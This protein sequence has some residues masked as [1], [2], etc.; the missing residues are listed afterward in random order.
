MPNGN[1]VISATKT[2]QKFHIANTSTTTTMT[3]EEF[4][5]AVNLGT[6]YSGQTVYLDE[7]VSGQTAIVGLLNSSHAPLAGQ[8]FSGTFEGQGHTLNVNISDNTDMGAAPFRGINGATIQNLVVSGSVTQHYPYPHASGL[9]GMLSGTNTIKNCL[10]HTNVTNTSYDSGNR[11]IGGITGH[12]LASTLTMEGCVYDGTL[13]SEHP[14][15]GLIG[16]SSASNLTLTN[17]F[18]NGRVTG[19]NVS[20]D[21]HYFHPIGCKDSQTPTVTVDNCYYTLSPT[22]ADNSGTCIVSVSTNK[23][24]F[25]YTITGASGVIVARRDNTTAT[26]NVSQL[27][28][29]N[30]AIVYDGTLYAASGESIPLNLSYPGYSVGAYSANHGTLSGSA[31]T[32]NNDPYTLAMAAYNTVIS[33]TNLVQKFHIANASNTTQMTWA[34]FAAAVN[35]GTNYSGQTVY[36]DEDIISTPAT[37]MVGTV[38]EKFK[39]TFNGQCYTLTVN[40]P[41]ANSANPYAPFCKTENAT[42]KNLKVTGSVNTSYPHASGLIGIVDGTCTI[43]NCVVNVTINSTVSGDCTS[44]GFVAETDSW[45][46]LTMVGCVFTGAFNG[47][48][49][50]CWGGLVGWNYG[51]ANWMMDSSQG[52]KATFTNCLFTPSSINV[53]NSDNAT[54]SRGWNDHTSDLTFNNCYYTQQLGLAQGKRGYT[55]DYAASP[56]AGGTVSHNLTSMTPYDCSCSG[57][58][59]YTLGLGY[60]I[61]NDNEDE[62]ILGNGESVTLTATANAS[63]TFMNWTDNTNTSTVNPYA[64]TMGT[65]NRNVTAR[66][67]NQKTGDDWTYFIDQ[68]SDVPTGGITISSGNVTIGNRE[69]LAW[70]ISMVNALNGVTAE[71]AETFAGLTYILTADVDMSAHTWVPIGTAE[72]PFQGTFEGNG[73]VIT[74]IRRTAEFPHQGLFGYVN[75]A[76]NIQNVVVNA[77][78]TGNSVTT[79]AI[80]G[81]FASTGTISNVEGAGTLTGGALTQSMGGLVGTNTSGTIHSSFAVATLT[82]AAS[83]TQMGGLVGINS[84]DLYNSYSNATY[85]GSSAPKGGLAGVNSGTIANCY[86]AGIVSGVSA[87]AGSNSGTIE[88]SYADAVGNGYVGTSGTAPSGCGLYGAVQS[89]TKHLNYMYRDNLITKGTNTYVGSDDAIADGITVYVGNHIPVWNGL[90]S[91]LNQWVRANPRSISGLTPW[92]RPLTTNINGDLPVLGFKKGTSLGAVASSPKV[93]RYGTMDALLTAYNGGTAASIF[94]YG[95]AKGVANVPSSNVSVYIAEDA[96]LLQSTTAVSDFSNT[97]VGVT[98]DN[99]DHGQH[100]FDFWGNRLMYDWHFMS[101]PLNNPL[102]GAEH[103]SYM[104]SGNANSDVDISAI[105]GY[106]PTGL[107]MALHDA[108]WKWDFYSYYEPEYHWINL[109]RNK[110]NHYH[111]DGGAQITYNEADQ[112]LGDHTAHLIPGKGYM[113][114]VSQTTLMNQGGT[115]NRGDVPVTL[116]NQEPDAIGGYGKGWNLVGNP[117]QAYLDLEAMDRLPVYIYDAEM[118]VYVPYAKSSSSNPVTPSRYIHPHQ[119]FFMHADGGSATEAFTFQQSWAD[120]TSTSDSYYREGRPN[121]PLVNLFA[122]NIIGQRDLAVIEFHRPEAGGAEKF[123][124]MRSVPFTLSVHHGGKGYGVFFATDELERVPLHFKADESD[125]MTLTW[126]THNGVFT[127]LYLVDNMTGVSCDMLTHDSYSFTAQATDYA[128]RFYITYEC[129]GTGVGEGV[130]ADDGSFA[131]VSG[132]NI[133]VEAEAGQATTMQVIDMLGRV[134]RSTVIAEGVHTMPAGGLAE[135]IYIIRLSNSKGAKAQKIVVR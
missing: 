93:L 60:D 55:L 10:V 31:H 12:A 16:W 103:T 73:H 5:A 97:T 68:L 113:M 81:T 123:E 111:Q 80:A 1:T 22:L 7:D 49:A 20:T 19:T 99:S 106:F 13:K 110:K 32:G 101:T 96:A 102:T 33:V 44:G 84:G 130:V 24:K 64:I 119:A 67:V 70:V 79:G 94:H 121:Y 34:E 50:N 129:S 89:S 42:I 116:T 2:T 66:F 75:S 47:S 48:N 40:L 135:G 120:T 69:G 74:G 95:K 127:Q 3:W 91:A 43:T 77:S 65:A 37:V 62:L 117:Y 87:L 78:L 6:S 118:G 83:T 88:Y 126:S 29:Y 128:S 122:E 4:A 36:L 108:D 15:G 114:A 28:A 30:P 21:D 45:A 17:C 56:V 38:T 9:V 134:V 27:N 11:H 125:R 112:D 132:G 58:T 61:D 98:F 109:K 35:D 71:D 25:A 41:T 8:S 76:A 133:V 39:G 14:K 63:Y 18:F 92:Y 82:G 51:H 59:P 46:T 52:C 115:L 86:A 57:I 85:A 54:L 72:H 90:V 26:Y 23:G 104:P 131:Y 53:I 105:G 124:A 100:A 107:P